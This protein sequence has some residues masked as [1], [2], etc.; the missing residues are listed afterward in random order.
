MC[1]GNKIICDAF[2]VRSLGNRS[3][4]ALCDGCGWYQKSRDAALA[5]SSAFVDYLSDP[6]LQTETLDTGTLKGHL[7]AAL[8]AAHE[9]IMKGLDRPEDAGQCTLIGGVLAQVVSYSSITCSVD[10]PPT[11]RTS[12][13]SISN[14]AM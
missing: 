9:A 14:D 3:V 12:H 4:L 6:V 8:D 11:N 10:S 7:R 5:A 1:V 13:N 2:R